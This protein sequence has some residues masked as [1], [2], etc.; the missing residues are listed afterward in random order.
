VALACGYG[1]Y[2]F[3]AQHNFPDIHVQPRETWSYTRAA[4][5][6]SSFL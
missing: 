4:L 6:S 5:E 3:Y 1:A 2:L